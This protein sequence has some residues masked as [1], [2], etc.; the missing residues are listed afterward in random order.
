MLLMK[1]N[2]SRIIKNHN[3]LQIQLKHIEPGNYKFIL[4]D[5]NNLLKI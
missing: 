5:D 2:K 4:F 3:Q 1:R